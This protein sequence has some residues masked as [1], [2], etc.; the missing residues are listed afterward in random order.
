MDGVFGLDLADFASS[1]VGINANLST[2][3][4]TG[5][6]NDELVSIEH[7]AGS[8]YDDTLI[9]NASVNELIGTCG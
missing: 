1:A 3:T 6:G 5:E 7:L 4:A 8:G 2:G 9:G